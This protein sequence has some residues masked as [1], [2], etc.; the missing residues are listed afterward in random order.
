MCLAIKKSKK[1]KENIENKIIWSCC[2]HLIISCWANY[3]ERAFPCHSIQFNT[4]RGCS[5]SRWSVDISNFSAQSVWSWSGAIIGDGDRRL[6][7]FVVSGLSLWYGTIFLFLEQIAPSRAA[8][9]RT[10]C[11]DF[12]GCSAGEMAS[13]IPEIFDIFGPQLNT[14]MSNGILLKYFRRKLFQSEWSKTLSNLDMSRFVPLT[15]LGFRCFFYKKSTLL[16]SKFHIRKINSFSITQ[17]K[18]SWIY[19]DIAVF[20][21]FNVSL[22]LRGFPPLA[23]ISP[24]SV[25]TEKKKQNCKL[26][27]ACIV[28]NAWCFIKAQ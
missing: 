11:V 16:R 15:K 25:A 28:S 8:H 20:Y 23:G 10:C 6:A 18:T 1:K 9:A 26:S 24:E 22:L 27:F 7:P 13:K 5:S 2:E 19:L 17:R 14:F 12:C 4:L 21:N 3:S